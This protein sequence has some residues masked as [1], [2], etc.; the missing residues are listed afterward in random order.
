MDFTPGDNLPFPGDGFTIDVESNQPNP[1]F[2][3]RRDFTLKIS[4]TALKSNVNVSCGTLF[5]SNTA[6]IMVDSKF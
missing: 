6:S 3:N 1:M 4:Y 2:P 5:N